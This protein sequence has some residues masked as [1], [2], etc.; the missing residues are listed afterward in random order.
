LT[1]SCASSTRLLFSPHLIFSFPPPLLTA[2]TSVSDELSLLRY[3]DFYRFFFFFFPPSAGLAPRAP[4]K[5]LTIPSVARPLVSCPS[6]PYHV[7][8]PQARLLLG[9]FDHP[10]DLPRGACTGILMT[11]VLFFTQRYRLD[12][13]FFLLSTYLLFFS[14]VPRSYELRNPFP[15]YLFRL[16]FSDPKCAG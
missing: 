3:A 8:L 7:F 15:S 5:G 16:F 13:P 14:F 2:T 6:V 12:A 4:L 9:S 1:T 10:A 11:P